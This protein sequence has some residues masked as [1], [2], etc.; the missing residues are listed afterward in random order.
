M[1]REDIRTGKKLSTLR[2]RVKFTTSQHKRS[3][4]LARVTKYNERLQTILDG[5]LEM[6]VTEVNL[7]GKC[8]SP[9]IRAIAHNIHDALSRSWVCKCKAHHEELVETKFCLTRDPAF[10]N[11]F[12]Y[13]FDL[14]FATRAEKDATCIEFDRWQESIIHTAPVLRGYLPHILLST[15]SSTHFYPSPPMFI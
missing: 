15:R 4:Y 6:D 5:T 2:I 11:S 14:L 7:R 10:K 12:Q 3:K 8:P 13:S 9:E 1:F